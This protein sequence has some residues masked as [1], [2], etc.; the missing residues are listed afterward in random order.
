[1]L[2]LIDCWERGR[3]VNPLICSLV[4]RNLK[5][6]LRRMVVQK[7][8]LSVRSHCIWLTSSMRQ[9]S[10]IRQYCGDNLITRCRCII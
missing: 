1:M 4:L 7:Q 6:H 9:K 10:F 3:K 2:F 5:L 8:N